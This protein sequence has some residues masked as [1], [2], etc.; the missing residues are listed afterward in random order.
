MRL[1]KRVLK[2]KGNF[3]EVKEKENYFI[4][5]L[6]LVALGDALVSKYFDFSVMFK[7]FKPDD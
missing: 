7:M 2:V 5:P 1:V 4:S 3:Y 6:S